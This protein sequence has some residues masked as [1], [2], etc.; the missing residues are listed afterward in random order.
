MVIGALVVSLVIVY[1]FKSFTMPIFG[2]GSIARLYELEVNGDAQYLLARGVDREQPVLLFV[3]GGPGMPA[4]YIAHDFQRG[5]EKEFVV[6]QWDQRA[7]GKSFK[8]NAEQVELST[9]ML[10]SD[11]DEV[12]NHLRDSV[13]TQSL[14]IVGHSHGSY[15]AA[16]YARRHPEK[17][18]A[19]VGI[20]QVA[21]ESSSGRAR[22]L[23]EAFLRTRLEDL[24]LDP[25]TVIDNT[26]LEE[27][28]FLSGSELYGETSFVPLLMSGLM[29]PEYSLFDA[30][31]IA[32]GSSLSSR[33]MNYDM[34]RDLLT[35]Q[36][37]F[38][39]PVALIMGRHDMVTPTE[40]ARDYYER[41]DAPQKA[42]Y[43]FEE[44]SH[45]PHFEQ[46]RKFAEALVELKG[47]WCLERE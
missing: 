30:L 11:M 1:T 12:V 22:S 34:P 23:Q 47:K 35:S 27:L 44:T 19:F 10:L 29:A 36:W 43:L 40:L 26:N 46:P 18:C 2:Q 9:S 41:I 45:F 38:E 39:V 8:R 16:L 20:G 21:D 28:L 42:W 32:K 14:W 5:L 17:L 13:G 4:M 37:Q 24:G 31:N 33:V 6:V 3:H 15:L 25:D 7:S